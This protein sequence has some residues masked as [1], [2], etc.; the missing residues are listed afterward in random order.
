MAAAE[1]GVY[2]RHEKRLQRGIRNMGTNAGRGIVAGRS[3]VIVAGN[4]SLS[5]SPTQVR[6]CMPVSDGQPSCWLPG[7]RGLAPAG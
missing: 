7:D 6:R 5:A 2:G 1:L 4:A 3:P